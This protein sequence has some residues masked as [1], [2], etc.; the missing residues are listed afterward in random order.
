MSR[1]SITVSL[2]V[3]HREGNVL[4]DGHREIYKF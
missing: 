2:V 3:N 4:G 1:Q